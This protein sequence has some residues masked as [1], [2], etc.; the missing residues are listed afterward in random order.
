MK[1]SFNANK[2]KEFQRI[3]GRIIEKKKLKRKK[4]NYKVIL[5]PMY[6]FNNYIQYNISSIYT[7]PV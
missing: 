6:L 5:I 3:K 2:V 1:I 7:Q 4:S